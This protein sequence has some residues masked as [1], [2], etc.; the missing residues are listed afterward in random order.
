MEIRVQKVANMLKSLNPGFHWAS[1]GNAKKNLSYHNILIL[2][3]IENL[4][5]KDQLKGIK[6]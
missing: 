6:S 1:Q 2:N 3:N 4:T 5:V